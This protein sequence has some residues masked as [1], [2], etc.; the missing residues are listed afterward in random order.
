M[1]VDRMTLSQTFRLKSVED[2]SQ[3]ALVMDTLVS[4]ALTGD[5]N[6]FARLYD[7]F[8]D[9][10]YRFIYFLVLDRKIAEDLT[11]HVFLKAWK[12][13]D[14]FKSR[15]ESFGAWLYLLASSAVDEE[16]R[17]HL[18]PAPAEEFMAFSSRTP[19]DQNIKPHDEVESL[20]KA[21]QT[22]DREQQEVMI[23]K[24]LSGITTDEIANHLGQ[25]ADY[26][27]ILQRNALQALSRHYGYS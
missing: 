11:A 6:S 9:G 27:K 4:D 15:E 10:I 17:A 22:L 23:L 20:G 21:L 1:S 7:Y 16:Q 26:V 14:R 13:L 5:S 12:N 8:V 18:E 25:S 24:F 19:L 2:D 3:A